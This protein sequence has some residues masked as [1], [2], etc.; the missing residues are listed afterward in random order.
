M[1]NWAVW[2]P[3]AMNSAQ[4]RLL[5]GSLAVAACLGVAQAGACA[6][7]GAP[8]GGPEDLRPPVVVRTEPDTF[9]TIDELITAVFDSEG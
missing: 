5:R 7:Q 8:P 2:N 6:R 3:E 9:A 1:W 4:S